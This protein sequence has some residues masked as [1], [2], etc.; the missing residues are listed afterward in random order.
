LLKQSKPN[1]PMPFLFFL[2]YYPL[3]LLAFTAVDVLSDSHDTPMGKPPRFTELAQQISKALDQ[4]SKHLPSSLTT[5]DLLKS[6]IDHNSDIYNIDADAYKPPP[7]KH[8]QSSLRGPNVPYTQQLMPPKRAKPQH[9]QLPPT[10]NMV[11]DERKKMDASFQSFLKKSSNLIQPL[12]SKK[13][14]PVPKAAPPHTEYKTTH[15]LSSMAM[16]EYDAH[17]RSSRS[18]KSSKNNG[19]N[20]G[21]GGGTSA[22]TAYMNRV[23]S[24]EAAATRQNGGS[25]SMANTNPT[26]EYTP[27]AKHFG[28]RDPLDFIDSFDPFSQQVGSAPILAA[29]PGKSNAPPLPNMGPGGGGGDSSLSSQILDSTPTY[30]Y[31]KIGGGGGGGGDSLADRGIFSSSND[32]TATDQ[33]LPASMLHMDG[34]VGRQG[35]SQRETDEAIASM[36]T[37]MRKSNPVKTNVAVGPV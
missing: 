2:S 18:S 15:D 32:K 28:Y 30:H 25:E 35:V 21:G 19:G 34:P 22:N 20:G 23:A 27:H 24:L 29:P 10:T 5:N 3:L 17:A 4:G 37:Q 1:I 31:T 36:V 26:G 6:S 12:E 14:L 11:E 13:T 7:N 16:A 33:L 9:R 8:T